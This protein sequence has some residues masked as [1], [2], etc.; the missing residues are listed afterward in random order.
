MDEGKAEMNR[1]IQALE[2]E[3]ENRVFFSAY[4]I[5]GGNAI[6]GLLKFDNVVL[7]IGNA[8]DSA[9]GTFTAPT[10][11]HF[12]FFFAGQTGNQKSANPDH[13]EL[14]LKKNGEKLM[15]IIDHLN[16]DIEKEDNYQNI[17]S[18]FVLDL[19][20]NDKITLE[21]YHG[22]YLWAET[23][24]RLTFTGHLVQF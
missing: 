11:G 15:E 3:K 18:H 1:R 2:Y 13:T 19:E 7:N 22:D 23:D 17:N 21:L 24:K 14:Y 8:Y 5:T 10:A 6:T 9:S 20:A 12:V 4:T 16:P